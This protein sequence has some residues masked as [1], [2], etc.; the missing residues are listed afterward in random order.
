MVFINFLLRSETDI[1]EWHP[2][3]CCHIWQFLLKNK[4]YLK[5]WVT[6]LPFQKEIVEMN[7]QQQHKPTAFFFP[8]GCYLRSHLWVP[9]HPFQYLTHYYQC[10][11]KKLAWSSRLGVSCV[12]SLRRAVGP[13]LPW[14]NGLVVLSL[15]PFCILV[16][17][18]KWEV[19]M[20]TTTKHIT[21]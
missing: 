16:F 15:A 6:N 19:V 8:E 1:A 17:P 4:K 3:S 2:F 14:H 12:S 5:T 11:W 9:L 21:A 13:Y 7:K 10:F 18:A 20:V